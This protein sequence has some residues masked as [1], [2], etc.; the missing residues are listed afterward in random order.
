MGRSRL[1]RGPWVLMVST[2]S[3]LA[4]PADRRPFPSALGTR[5]ASGGFLGSNGP[6][7]GTPVAGSQRR[8]VPAGPETRP[9]LCRRPERQGGTAALPPTACA[10][11]GL[12][13]GC[14]SGA[15]G[16]GRR[17]ENSGA[18]QSA[19][20]AQWGPAC[21]P[22]APAPEPRVQGEGKGSWHLAGGG[23]PNAATLLT[24]VPA[25]R[26]FQPQP[27]EV[28][29]VLQSEGGDQGLG[30]RG[31][32]RGASVLISQVR[33][34]LSHGELALDREQA[35]QPQT[36]TS[37]WLSCDPQ[38]LP[39]PPYPRPGAPRVMAHVWRL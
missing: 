20:G 13:C 21:G 1:S 35:G 15:W 3:A 16:A 19:A 27:K 22:L 9:S 7:T 34:V 11:K 39:L 37:P 26:L 5:G 6:E 28:G 36:P 32:L 25:A 29:V 33:E 12:P 24:A 2:A 17:S 14:R 31:G 30:G 4:T 8:W 38:R 10:C 23:G 18:T